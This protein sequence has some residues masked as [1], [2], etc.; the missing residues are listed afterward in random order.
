MAWITTLPL[1]VIRRQF[2]LFFKLIDLNM[3]Y[4][5]SN[6][7]CYAFVRQR[8]QNMSVLHPLKISQM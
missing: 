6:V 1:N 7:L 8:Q 2:T 5:T 3:I 4:W